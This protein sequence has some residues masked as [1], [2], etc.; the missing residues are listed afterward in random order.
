MFPLFGWLFNTEISSSCWYSLALL[1]IGLLKVRKWASATV[2]TCAHFVARGVVFGCA[3]GDDLGWA[4]SAGC[5]LC[6]SPLQSG[7]PIFLSDQVRK[8]SS[9]CR[10]SGL[11]RNKYYSRASKAYLVYPVACSNETIRARSPTH[12]HTLSRIEL[13]LVRLSRNTV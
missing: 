7:R 5:R 1:N 12:S 9:L 10:H 2:I 4:S 8:H 6:Q 3:S 11:L 13:L